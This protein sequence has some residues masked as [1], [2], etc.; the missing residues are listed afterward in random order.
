MKKLVWGCLFLAVVLAAGGCTPAQTDGQ[1]SAWSEI[2]ASSSASSTPPSSGQASTSDSQA[3]T[4]SAPFTAEENDGTTATTDPTCGYPR[5]GQIKW[6]E[7]ELDIPENQTP[8]WEILSYYTG[9]EAVQNTEVRAEMEAFSVDDTKV[10]IYMGN[11]GEKGLIYSTNY[12]LE[13]QTENGWQSLPFKQDTVIEQRTCYLRPHAGKTRTYSLTNLEQPAVPGI[14]R[15]IIGEPATALTCTFTLRPSEN[16]GPRISEAQAYG[17]QIQQTGSGA[18]AVIPRQ[19]TYPVGVQSIQ[20]DYVNNSDEPYYFGP[21]AEDFVLEK[22][23][24]G[25]WIRIPYNTPDMA[26][27][28]I[29]AVVPSHS[30]TVK[31]FN[32][33]VLQ[34]PLLT[35]GQYRIL[36]GISGQDDPS[37]FIFYFSLA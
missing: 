10:P 2:P 18:V 25:Q 26:I 22:L 20:A 37:V 28:S 27:N 19:R 34:Q 4:S 3:S 14:Y 17:D 24:D 32:L 30:T 9:E 31:T 35:A 11:K 1:A 36:E 7:A 12:R 23:Q 15:I 21:V 5:A 33:S 29:A 16:L 13:R 8:D 6:D